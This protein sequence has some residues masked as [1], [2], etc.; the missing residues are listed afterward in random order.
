MI[1]QFQCGRFQLS[2]DRPLIMGVVNVT[3]TPFPTAAVSRAAAAIA[4]RS[5]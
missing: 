4:T 1:V 3:P 2:L 5:S